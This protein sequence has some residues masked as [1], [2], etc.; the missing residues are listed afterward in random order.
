MPDIM[1]RDH[2]RPTSLKDNSSITYSLTHSSITSPSPTI[3]GPVSSGG[4]LRVSSAA[5]ASANCRLS[6]SSAFTNGQ[7]KLVKCKHADGK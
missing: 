4:F 6:F 2:R 5:S 1:Q 7:M 3:R